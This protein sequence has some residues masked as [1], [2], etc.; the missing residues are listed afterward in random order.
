[1]FFWERTL[2]WI[3]DYHGLSYGFPYS[4]I[5]HRLKWGSICASFLNFER[6]FP[7]MVAAQFNCDVPDA[8][9]SWLMDV[10]WTEYRSLIGSSMFWTDYI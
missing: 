7:R 5:I 9:R 1:M 4:Y 10:D 8:I 2:Q 3:M 6:P